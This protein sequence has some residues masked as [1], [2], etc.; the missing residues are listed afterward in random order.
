[1]IKSIVNNEVNTF[2]QASRGGL[3]LVE[4]FLNHLTITHE[5][6]NVS[7]M[8]GFGD[9]PFDDVLNSRSIATCLG[10][11]DCEIF[12]ISLNYLLANRIESFFC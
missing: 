7:L 5:E 10:N 12:P 8:K 4:E 11:S 9:I 2:E 3:A 6:L 1:M